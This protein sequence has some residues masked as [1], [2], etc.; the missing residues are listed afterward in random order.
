M[1]SIESLQALA[2]SQNCAGFINPEAS[3]NELKTT[4]M[5]HSIITAMPTSPTSTK[6]GHPPKETM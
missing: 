1:P 3:A 5:S 6:S 2:G 4:M